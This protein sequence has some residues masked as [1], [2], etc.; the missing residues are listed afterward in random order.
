MAAL[1]REIGLLPLLSSLLP[2]ITPPT[3]QY[4]LL[5]RPWPEVALRPGRGV[6][7]AKAKGD[8]T[9]LLFLRGRSKFM[10]NIPGDIGDEMAPA[11]GKTDTTL[12][13]VRLV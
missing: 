12:K 10:E 4:V 11:I 1:G 2:L 8:L 13:H 9:A 6:R 3:P 7:Q 5:R